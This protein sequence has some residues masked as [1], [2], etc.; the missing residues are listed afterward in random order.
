MVDQT[1]E[2]IVLECVDRG[3]ASLGPSASQA[4]FWHIE[5]N[6]RLKHEEIPRKPGQFIKVLE[7]MLG[8]GARLLEGKIVD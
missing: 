2:A 1:F 3:M 4:I 8:P 7:E 6:N 5:R